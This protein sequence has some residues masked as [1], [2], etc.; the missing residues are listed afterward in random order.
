MGTGEDEE[1]GANGEGKDEKGGGVLFPGGKAHLVARGCFAF[2][3]VA[4][5]V[6]RQSCALCCNVLPS[7]R[8]ERRNEGRMFC[9]AFASHVQAATVGY[10]R[11]LI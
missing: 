6:R 8:K 5:L 10:P 1:A 4:L 7:E 11:G 3:R 9:S 2:R